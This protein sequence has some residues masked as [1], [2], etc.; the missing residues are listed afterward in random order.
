M[1]IYVY[2][3]H[4]MENTPNQNIGFVSIPPHISIM[5]HID[6][7]GQFIFYD[8]VKHGNAKLFQVS[9][10]AKKMQVTYR[11]FHG[12]NTRHVHLKALT[13]IYLLQLYM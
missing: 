3:D 9:M 8:M 11:I 13:G 1:F 2:F 4:A 5:H 6:C 10:Y 7:V 12:I